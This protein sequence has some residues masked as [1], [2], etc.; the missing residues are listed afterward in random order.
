MSNLNQNLPESLKPNLEKKKQL[1]GMP[2]HLTYKQVED[3]YHQ[4]V[5]GRFLGDI[6]FGANDGLVTTFA[7]VAGA[8]GAQLSSTV[9]IIVGF[10]NLLADGLS[11][12]LGNYLG[13]KSELSYQI[14]QR[15]KEK[16]EIKNFPEIEK[17]EIKAVFQRWGFQGND[18][19]RAVDIITNNREAWIDIMMTE[20]LGIVEDKDT[21]PK[22]H[23]LITFLSFAIAAFIPLIPYLIGLEGW[24]AFYISVTMTAITLFFVG[25][26]RCRLS[27]IKFWKGGVE[28]LI[29]GGIA[30]SAAYFI[31]D[32]L[33]RI[34]D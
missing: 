19:E 7:V 34:L 33:K 29:I 30:S 21:Q 13:K 9:I 6:I 1:L 5:S 22:Q 15:Q 23:G 31:G 32:I 16:W 4:K 8:V 3:I 20:E 11:M 25:A 18:L 26:F 12:G 24:A 2:E 27:V 10:A 28:M 14:S 17:H